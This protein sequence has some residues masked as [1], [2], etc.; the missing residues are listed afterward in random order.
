MDKINFFINKFK[1]LILKLIN[2]QIIKK[3]KA[4]NLLNQINFSQIFKKSF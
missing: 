1:K 3:N 2:K 4:L